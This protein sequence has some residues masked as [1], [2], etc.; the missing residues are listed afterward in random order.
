MGAAASAARPAP[1]TVDLSRP[2]SLAMLAAR[3]ASSCVNALPT[4]QPAVSCYCRTPSTA[5]DRN[6]AYFSPIFRISS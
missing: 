4:K 5:K 1:T 6:I 2:G 3:A